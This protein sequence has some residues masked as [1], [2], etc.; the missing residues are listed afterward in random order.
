MMGYEGRSTL[1]NDSYEWVNIPHVVR[2]F[3][4]H[5]NNDMESSKSLIESIRR[6]Q[7]ETSTLLRRVVQKQTDLEIDNARNVLT[8]RNSASRVNVEETETRQ[9][10]QISHLR[11]KCE[12]LSDRVKTLEAAIQDISKASENVSSQASEKIGIVQ[13]CFENLQKDLAEQ[14]IQT[15]QFNDVSKGR[16]MELHTSV[17]EWVNE[18]LQKLSLQR[19]SELHRVEE[20]IASVR[21]LSEQ[22]NSEVSKL[23]NASA[24]TL[25]LSQSIQKNSN[26][27][28]TSL[29]STVEKLETLCESHHQALDAS[30]IQMKKELEDSIT[31]SRNE[32]NTVYAELRGMTT[33]VK[34]EFDSRLADVVVDA[35]KTKEIQ[36]HLSAVLDDTNREA[37]SQKALKQCKDLFHRIELVEGSLDSTTSL[38]V[39]KQVHEGST[40]RF[41][42]ALDTLKSSTS[43]DY[44]GLRDQLQQLSSAVRT[45]RAENGDDNNW[46][47]NELGRIGTVLTYLTQ[48]KE[49]Q[50]E[51]MTSL[52][53]VVRNVSTGLEVIQQS[54]AATQDG[55]DAQQSEEKGGIATAATIA[56]TPLRTAFVSEDMLA[57]EL[58]AFRM[59]V[60]REVGE[61]VA[62][63]KFSASHFAQ[64]LGR[65][66]A[67]VDDNERWT[68]SSLQ[69]ADNARLLMKEE[70]LHQLQVDFSLRELTAVP[71]EMD[72]LK[73][74][75]AALENAQLDFDFSVAL[76]KVDQVAMTVCQKYI[77]QM[78]DTSQAQHR[79][80]LDFEHQMSSFDQRIS[81]LHPA[82][83]QC[84]KDYTDLQHAVKRLGT[85]V[86]S[87][88]EGLSRSETSLLTHKVST[89]KR[90]GELHSFLSQLTQ[91]ST[92][93]SAAVTGELMAVNSTTHS[94]ASSL[95]AL[96]ERCRHVESEMV[97]CSL[98]MD[99]QDA[100]IVAYTK[101]KE[102]EVEKS[103]E[104]VGRQ[105]NASSHQLAAE[106]RE[107]WQ[108]SEDALM[109]QV[110]EQVECLTQKLH[111]AETSAQ[112]RI[113]ALED[114][115]QLA[116]RTADGLA[117]GISKCAAEVAD[118][119]ERV[120][121]MEDQ[122][123]RH[124]TDS[125]SVGSQVSPPTGAPN[126]LI[127]D[128]AVNGGTTI[129]A[130]ASSRRALGDEEYEA[131][132]AT[133]RVQL[134]AYEKKMT[135]EMQREYTMR[136]THRLEQR[137]ME[138]AAQLSSQQLFSEE[139]Q[140]RHTMELLRPYLESNALMRY[141][142]RHEMSNMKSLL[143]L[144]QKVVEEEIAD[145]RSSV[146]VL[147]TMLK[148]RSETA[149][150]TTAAVTDSSPNKVQETTATSAQLAID[151]EAEK[152]AL[153]AEVLSAMQGMYYPNTQL[154]ERLENIWSSVASLLA[155]KED[156]VTLNEKL[157]EL[158]QRVMAEVEIGLERLE[159]EVQNQLVQKASVADLR[160]LLEDYVTFN[161][162]E[163][164]EETIVT[165]NEK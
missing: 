64:Q 125:L 160:N 84:T 78:G 87:I 75:I 143:E 123:R 18:T 27:R 24:E 15:Q 101:K 86:T 32:M 95:S 94:T 126:S 105:F 63:E 20:A 112:L 82:I 21:Q 127:A 43:D 66:S 44:T 156:V 88:V 2:E 42:D 5:L 135:A 96:Q 16:V 48:Q 103:V 14:R 35:K 83:S 162:E 60:M 74:R 11:K 29:C 85:D 144:H 132:V 164:E 97:K 67:K 153:V 57:S 10:E 129:A 98:R 120:C 99:E 61:K 31:A 46:L 113:T 154:E 145:L 41:H 151:P 152:A 139:M 34:M 158:H 128:D 91:Q 26:E 111:V 65:L 58:D 6:E 131:L 134:E 81:T 12:K 22:N 39:T 51:R 9:S 55:G 47:H 45:M 136:L 68:Q 130:D 4:K 56:D 155:R 40:R 106:L 25:A 138:E 142:T 7:R 1:L 89:E 52:C 109:Q 36:L 107:E 28:F 150:S 116:V 33:E 19:K 115:L 79:C 59:I 149:A 13:N 17:K 157:N 148:A 159:S 122:L 163:E 49:K 102:G 100:K 165:V 117:E 124:L 69:D 54:H 114:G 140:K 108:K 90:L 104:E 141:T 37:I 80:M 53:E 119:P 62:G 38:F 137:L 3:L 161:L 76:K 8:L 93:S 71:I 23:R 50:E 121:L 133:I 73:K 92:A 77:S 70:V 110:M 146:G 118:V 72:S 147:Q 30:M